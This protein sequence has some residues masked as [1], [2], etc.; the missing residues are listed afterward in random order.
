MRGGPRRR[1]KPAPGV[2]EQRINAMKKRPCHREVAACGPSKSQ[3]P[4]P[5]SRPAQSR[6]R[7]GEQKSDALPDHESLTLAFCL[8]TSRCMN[9][10]PSFL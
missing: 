6:E 3:V 7:T 8:A 9:L 1:R 4:I 2:S 5:L 10:G